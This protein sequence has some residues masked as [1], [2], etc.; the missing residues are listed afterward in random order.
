MI[1]KLLFVLILGFHLQ[2]ISSELISMGRGS[3]GNPAVFSWGEGARVSVGKFCSI[4]DGVQIFVGGNHRPDWITTYPFNVLR[5]HVAGHII[6]HPMTKGNVIIG[7]DVWIGNGAC[8]MSGVTIG[9]GAVIGAKAVVAKNIPAYAIAVGNPAR[10]VRYRFDEE[11]RLK[12]L[13]IAWWDWS[14]AE[15]NAAVSLLLSDDSASFLQ[16]CK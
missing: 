3:Y 16:Y 10:V 11:T 4:A 9:D 6:G 5:P 8:I 2:A 1:K 15:I 14:D 13:E 12:L 7:N